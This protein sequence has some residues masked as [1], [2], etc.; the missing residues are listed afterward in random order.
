MDRLR[1]FPKVSSIIPHSF[2]TGHPSVYITVIRN[3]GLSVS[4]ASPV[5]ANSNKVQIGSGKAN[6]MSACGV[7][8]HTQKNGPKH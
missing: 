4:V 2:S 3:I 1:W 7:H 6:C 5:A 8:T